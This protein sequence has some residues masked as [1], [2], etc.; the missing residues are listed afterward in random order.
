M[1]GSVLSEQLFTRPR[2]TPSMPPD[3]FA[4]QMNELFDW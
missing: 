3:T 1:K 2:C 4:E